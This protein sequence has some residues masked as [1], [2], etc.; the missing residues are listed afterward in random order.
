[1]GLYTQRV[2]GEVG[3]AVPAGVVGWNEVITAVKASV[4]TLHK[5]AQSS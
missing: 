2:W 5:D 1:M 3:E 4:W